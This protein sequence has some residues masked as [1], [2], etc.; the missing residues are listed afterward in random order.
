M[1]RSV[2]VPQPYGSQVLVKIHAVSLNFRDVVI[3]KNMY[4]IA[5]VDIV[6]CSDGA[7]EVVAVGQD[8]KKWKVGDRVLANFTT[9]LI[10][11]DPT[12][13]TQGTSLGGAVDGVLSEYQ[14]F[15][16]YVSGFFQVIRAQST[17]RVAVSS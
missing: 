7:G 1:K 9:D 17:K 12:P 11:G 5:R 15:P 4:P 14:V 3:A 16:D 10:A 13:T 2:T 6:P 8:V